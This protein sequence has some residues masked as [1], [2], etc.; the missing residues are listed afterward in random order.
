VTTRPSRPR[1]WKTIAVT[2]SLIAIGVYAAVGGL[3]YVF[4]DSLIFLPSRHR[5][6]ELEKLARK[7]GYVEWH[8]S[9]GLQI[10]WQSTLGNPA[11]A[12]V[13][14]HGQGGNALDGAFLGKYS[15]QLGGDWKIFLLEYPGYGNRPGIP[16]EKSLTACAVGAVDHL[17]KTPGRRIWV[18]GQSLGSGVA[19]AAAHERP[20]QIAGLILLTPFN[21]LVATAAHKYPFIP[22]HQFLRTRFDSVQN[23]ASFPG[24]VAFFFCRRDSTIPISLGRKLYDGYT[25]RKKI[26]IDPNRDHDASEILHAEWVELWQWMQAGATG[27]SLRKLDFSDLNQGS[28]P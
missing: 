1:S 25:G 24:P 28:N 9:S 2:A 8:D 21:S 15:A 14:L 20:D 18:V 11:N 26:W 23:L 10:G 4:Q 7:E 13:F 5:H 3:L 19:C 17:A 27:P 12:L 6:G 16:S 22:V